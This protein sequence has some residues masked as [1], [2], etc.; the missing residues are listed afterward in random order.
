[1]KAVQNSQFTGFFALQSG[2]FQGDV[3]EPVEF[4]RIGRN[5]FPFVP[6][7]AGH[8]ACLSRSLAGKQ[9][10]LEGIELAEAEGVE[11][12]VQFA[13]EEPVVEK[14][15]FLFVGQVGLDHA[16]EKFRILLQKEKIE[17]VTS[18]LGIFFTL[19]LFHHP[20]PIE[21]EC[22]FPKGGVFPNGKQEIVGVA[23]VVHEVKAGGG[24]IGQLECF[25]RVDHGHAF[26]FGK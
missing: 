26:L 9:N 3:E 24:G 25:A 6:D 7:V 5:Q 21:N 12:F 2:G 15:R 4:F 20:R 17:L 1:M 11:V 13:T 8:G 10:F 22:E 14:G 18:V 19:L 23:Q 16:I